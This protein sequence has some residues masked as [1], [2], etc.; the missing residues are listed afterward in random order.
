MPIQATCPTCEH[1]YNVPDAQHGKRVRCRHCADVFVVGGGKGRGRDVDDEAE[2]DDS[3]HAPRRKRASGDDGDLR[4]R[5]DRDDLRPNRRKGR[6]RDD[7]DPDE[8]HDDEDDDDRPRNSS[9]N[10]YLVPLLIGIGGVVLLVVIGGGVAI[11]LAAS[12]NVQKGPGQFI[13]A[14][15]RNN[16]G[17]FVPGPG[18]IPQPP[19]PPPKRGVF[20]PVHTIDEALGDIREQANDAFVPKARAE[21]LANQPIQENRRQEVC[22]ALWNLSQ[23]SFH[24]FTREAAIGAFCKWAGPGQEKELLQLVEAGNGPAMEAAAKLKL[25]KLVPVL[26]KKLPDWQQRGHALRHL[27]TLGAPLAEK[28]VVQYL[29]H[30]DSGLRNDVNN[31]LRKWGTKSEV[32]VDRILIDLRDPKPE[33]VR[34][35]LEN[36]GKRPVEASRQEAVVK[37]IRPLMLSTDRDVANR[38]TQ[39]AL[40]WGT[41]DIAPDL[42]AVLDSSTNSADRVAIMKALIKFDTEPCREAIVRQLTTA[43]R[44]A[45]E[46][47]IR[48]TGSAF[49]PAVIACLKECKD[50]LQQLHL[51]RLLG[52]I[53]TPKS[54]QVLTTL[55]QS[56]RQLGFSA[57]RAIQQIQA[58]AKKP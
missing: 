37:A 9:G 47:T 7:D 1:S 31:L 27:E 10:G 50:R 12:G 18:P 34:A 52:D 11:Y 39:A 20:D 2:A 43:N 30:P 36:L 35:A 3:D 33:V 57:A 28:E 48:E 54:Q 38:A 22:N 15:N 56:D 55:G 53:G 24:H 41:A 44:F 23:K 4:G 8:D 46:R 6:G 16:G 14:N 29:N 25:P 45:A 58:R 19:G 51:I 13:R 49:E 40:L 21:W 32:I 26:A 42:I 5:L 17:L